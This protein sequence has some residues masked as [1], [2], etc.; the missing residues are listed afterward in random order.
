M[1]KTTS[2]LKTVAVV[3]LSGMA[4]DWAVDALLTGKPLEVRYNTAGS[5]W[6]FVNDG[7]P[8][9]KGPE[10]F[11]SDWA[12]GGP[13]LD[14]EDIC[15]LRVAY[16][17]DKWGASSGPRGALVSKLSNPPEFRFEPDELSYGP[18]PL[19]AAMRCYVASKSLLG[20]VDVP[21]ALLQ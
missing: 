8:Y 14:R 4:L 7:V 3:D 17:K 21:S 19:I 9:Q 2:E 10:K 6:I 11:S 12:K 18:T 20:T 1:K 15:T 16:E 13:I 5:E